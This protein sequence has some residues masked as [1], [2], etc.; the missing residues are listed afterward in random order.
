MK[1]KFIAASTVA[2]TL[3]AGV[4]AQGFRQRGPQNGQRTDPGARMERFLTRSLQLDASQ[5]NQLHTFIEENRVATQ[6]L[7]DQMPDLRKGLMEAIKANNTAQID[8][9]TTQMGNIEQ[10]LSAARAKTAAKFYAVLNDAQ[11]ADL[12]AR[13]GMLMGGFGPGGFGGPMGR[14]GRGPGGP[15]PAATTP[16]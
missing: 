7:R 4:Y 5:Q 16:Q 14:G 2:L 3:A 15:P 10:Q 8:T 11:K 13:I 6:S 12:G 9:L 1:S